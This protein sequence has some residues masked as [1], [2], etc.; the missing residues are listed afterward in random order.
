MLQLKKRATVTVYAKDA[1]GNK[2]K[3]IEAG[4]GSEEFTLVDENKDI[5]VASGNKINPGNKT[6]SE[7]VTVLVN[8]VKVAT[9]T[10]NVVDTTASLTKVTQVK[11]AITV[12]QGSS[13]EDALFGHDNN[14]TFVKGAFVAYDQY[15]AV[16]N[17][18]SVTPYIYSADTTIIDGTTLKANGNVLLTIVVKDIVYTITVK[19]TG[20]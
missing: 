17:F 4:I 9:F 6:G 12:A 10:V 1:N 7:K 15:G 20:F 3:A 18:S 19:V 5:A 14:G 16:V 13:L 8:G 2:I 11:N